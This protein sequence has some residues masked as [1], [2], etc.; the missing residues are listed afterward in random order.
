MFLIETLT[1]KMQPIDPFGSSKFR[2]D[3]YR[4]VQVRLK[5]LSVRNASKVFSV[6]RLSVLYV[7]NHNSYGS[8]HFKIYATIY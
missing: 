6:F 5:I 3:G 1:T 2:R 7:F 8:A 4:F